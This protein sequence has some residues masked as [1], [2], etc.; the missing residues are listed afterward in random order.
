MGED[1]EGEE[2]EVAEVVNMEDGVDWRRLLSPPVY[3]LL[4]FMAP[5]L[6]HLQSCPVFEAGTRREVGVERH[7]TRLR[8]S[9]PFQNVRTVVFPFNVRIFVPVLF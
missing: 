3:S 9:I 7:L 2:G 1:V 4:R 8:L 6:V 5:A